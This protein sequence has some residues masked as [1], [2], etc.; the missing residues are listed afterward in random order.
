MVGGPGVRKMVVL[1][2]G[3][4]KVV[5]DPR[6]HCPAGEGYAKE[7]FQCRGWAGAVAEGRERPRGTVVGELPGPEGD[8]H[9]C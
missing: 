9:R 4:E 6:I 7:G 3:Q 5:P 1:E 2:D 8:G